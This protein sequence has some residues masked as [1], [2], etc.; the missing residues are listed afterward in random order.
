MVYN[1]VDPDAAEATERPAASRDPVVLFLG[2]VTFQ[3][4]PDYF[5]EAARA[6][7]D[8]EP[9]ATLRDGGHAATCCR[10]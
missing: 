7:L 9:D 1:A 8:E 6:V 3:K 10:A 5:L 4:G 2:R